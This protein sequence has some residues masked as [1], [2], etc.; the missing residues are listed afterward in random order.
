M[1]D[2]KRPTIRLSVARQA[3]ILEASIILTPVDSFA[4]NEA[5]GAE[6]DKLDGLYATDRPR[7]LEESLK[8]K[9][10]FSGRQHIS[11]DISAIYQKWS[12]ALFAD[13]LS[14]RLLSGLH[15]HTTIFMGV[16]R[17][18]ETVFLLPEKAGGHFAT[19]GILERLGYNVVE[20]PV[21]LDG[22]RIDMA[23]SR[24]M[25]DESLGGIL[26]IDRSEGLV[27]EDFSPL[28]SNPALYCIYDAS[29][30]LP[31][32]LTG[33]YQ[34]PFSMGFDLVISTLHKSFPGPQKALVATRVRDERWERVKR[35]MSQ[36]VSSHHI[37]STYMAGLGLEDM[38]R[39]ERY[40]DRLLANA[41][42]LEDA[43]A[44]LDVNVIR[45]A[46]DAPPTQHLWI[47]F[48]N[49][50]DAFNAYRQLEFC[51]IYCNY[52]LLPYGLGHGLRLGTT[53]ITVCGLTRVLIP[54][55]AR[56]ISDILHGGGTLARRHAVRALT[57]EIAEHN[58]LRFATRSES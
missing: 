5:P 20:L 57:Q 31:A 30:Y 42:A 3:R 1:S 19:A 27:Y 58:G 2:Y 45:R 7:G 56:L 11:H 16:G 40:T 37:R 47:R 44:T 51:R 48:E 29:Q 12:R 15:A 4:L 18:G 24:A 26:F 55:L 54:K 46:S 53:A 22:H 23:R 43:L 28:T 13:D 6:F 8:S 34:S 50:E 36:F 25:I 41:V 39:L 32:I 35:A 33:R 10:L 14:M 49:A 21:D 52:R 9:I 17:L 38:D